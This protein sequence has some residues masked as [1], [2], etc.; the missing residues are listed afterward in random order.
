MRPSSAAT[1][2]LR[3]AIDALRRRRR[4]EP[5]PERDRC[6]LGQA[7]AEHQALLRERKERE[8]QRLGL[9][10]LAGRGRETRV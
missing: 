6:D 7:I 4:A 3:P 9:D 5:R 8:A 1:D 2:D 10:W